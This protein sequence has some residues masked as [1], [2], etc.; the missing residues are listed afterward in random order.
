[1][2]CAKSRNEPNPQTPEKAQFRRLGRRFQLLKNSRKLIQRARSALKPAQQGFFKERAS[3][4]DHFG[5][6]IR[7]EQD[8]CIVEPFEQ[9]HIQ[10]QFTQG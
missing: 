7:I 4:R 5:F 2:P 3:R 10:R 1:M 6:T 8:R 9:G